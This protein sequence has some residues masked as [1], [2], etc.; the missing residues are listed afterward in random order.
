MR[1]SFQGRH[2]PS[3]GWTTIFLLL[4]VGAILL[5]PTAQATHTSGPNCNRTIK[6]DVVA[7]DQVFFWNRLG[8]V[9]PHG[10][11]YALRRDIV[12]INSAAGLTPGNVML[13]PDKRPRPLVLRMG[14]GD[15]LRIEFQNLLRTQG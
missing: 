10:M 13:R 6:A 14:V 9:Q 4:T 5:S 1:P 12:P 7:L 11:I 2:G 15:C 3:R 8:A